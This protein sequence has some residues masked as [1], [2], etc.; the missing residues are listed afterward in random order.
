MRSQGLS[1]RS[2]IATAHSR[3]PLR[4]RSRTRRAVCAFTCQIGREDIEHLGARHVGDRPRADPGKGVALQTLPPALRVPAVHASRHASVPARAGRRR[5]MSASSP[6]GAFRRAGR[7]PRGQA[8]VGPRLL[9]RLGQRDQRHAA[10]PQVASAAVD[11]E[12]LDPASGAGRLDVEIESLAIAVSSGRGGAHEAGGQPFV[13]M[14]SSG[15]RLATR[16]WRRFRA[17][18]TPII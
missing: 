7:R 15:L 9:A 3:T 1:L 5:Q 17:M 8:A 4:I 2:S 16:S 10:E 14:A 13:W 12:P 18:H 11:H 6:R